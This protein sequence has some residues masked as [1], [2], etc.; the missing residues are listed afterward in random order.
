MKKIIGML[1]ALATM[2]A[3]FTG[4]TDTG[5]GGSSNSG[6]D[7][8]AFD[9][10]S[11]ITV[12]S[13]EP[14]SGTR[15]AFVELFGV[16]EEDADGNTVDRTTEGAE[17]ASRT[18]V[19][20]TSV[21]SNPYAIGYVSLG[22]LNDTVKALKIGG[23]EA[24]TD[25]VK[26]G[27]YGVSGRFN[28]ATK[29]EPTGVVKDFINF[30]LSKEGQEIISGDY[31]PVVDNAESFTS[32]MSSGQISIGGSSSVTPVMQE[33]IEAYQQINTNAQIEINQTDS[34]SG[35]NAA[36]DG[37]IDIGMASRELKD[38]EKADLTPVQIA[39]DG[40]AIVVNP[41]NTVEDLTTDQVKAIYVGDV[42]TWADATN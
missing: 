37:T 9:T 13:R 21:A 41:E 17:I 7:A 15:G 22:S 23:V 26:N 3:V 40:I 28:I 25:N 12:I 24:T 39:L 35:M 16:E 18:D 29:G 34:S 36:M 14:G 20:L 31:I 42:T 11:E 10:S 30:I 19:V 8:A 6:A 33:L 2:A 1:L 4:C 38:S 5:N 32:D 27:T